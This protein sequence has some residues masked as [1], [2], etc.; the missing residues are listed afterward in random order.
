M[1]AWASLT[2]PPPPPAIN[3]YI[4]CCSDCTTTLEHSTCPNQRSLL[5]LKMRL[6]SSSS[7]FASSSLYLTMAIS[8]GLILQI[9][10]IMGLSVRCR[11]I[12]VAKFHWHGTWRS[13]GKSC[14]HGHRSSGPTWTSLCGLPSIG[15]A[16]PMHTYNQD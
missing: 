11:F 15:W 7:R 3:L 8:S 13:A 14:I 2:P 9:S 6:W 1:L 16:F 4:T 10:L 12:L 5:S